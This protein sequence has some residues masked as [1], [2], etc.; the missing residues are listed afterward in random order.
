MLLETQLLLIQ[1]LT[2]FCSNVSMMVSFLNSVHVY[3]YVGVLSI[4]VHHVIS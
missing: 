1:I 4:C 2:H 3:K